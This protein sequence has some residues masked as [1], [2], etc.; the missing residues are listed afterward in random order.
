MTTPLVRWHIPWLLL[1]AARAAQAANGPLSLEDAVALAA[2]YAPQV[3][4][5]EAAIDG[6]RAMS[7]GAGR[8]PDPELVVGVDN[9]PTN[10]P[11]AYSL[12]NDFM[13][14]RKVGVMQ[15]FPNGRKRAAQ[16]LQAQASVSVAELEGVQARL[17]A[18]QGAA[19]AWVDVHAAEVGLQGLRELKPDL[20]TQADSA[21]AA[22]AG[23]RATVYDAVSAQAAVADLDDRI[24][25]ARREVETGRAGLGR[26]IGE[27]ADRTLAS[28]PTFDTLPVGREEMLATLH[29][30]A[31]L[32]AYDA[33]IAAANS[34]VALAR[35]DRHPDWSAELDYG[36]R[37]AA[38]SDMV[39]L[40]FR[41]GLP[42]W[43]HYRQNPVIRERQAT[44]RQLE[45]D[46]ETTLRMHATEVTR[47]L[48]SWEAAR[49]RLVLYD[50]VRLPL[51]RQRS[52]LAL[53]AFQA[54]RMDLRSTL[55]TF[56]EE[57][58]LRRGHAELL[59]SLGHAWA[60][61]NYLTVPGETP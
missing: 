46:R 19:D 45:A 51:A 53:A 33:R 40:Q 36:R 21:R 13:T 34:E 61:L 35:A 7:L 55:T 54:G 28:P 16:R 60:F 15:S 32:S 6:A 23:G 59:G 5:K 12:G 4:A 27:A 56:A 58:E 11:D 42:L 57:I 3:A 26:W 1:F 2:R 14:M 20:D 30:H 43:P 10:G 38:Y 22:L 24:L 49:D 48:E 37:G 18:A 52:Q 50:T 9:L 17:E 44:V 41:V 8:L 25:V 39:S 47:M 29:R 31:E